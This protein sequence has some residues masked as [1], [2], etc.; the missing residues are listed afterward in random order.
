MGHAHPLEQRADA[1][2]MMERL[3][4]SSA[5]AP[6]RYADLLRRHGARLGTPMMRL[7]TA[8]GAL[9]A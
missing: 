6:W 1:I 3:L 4:R 2:E 8:V 7:H 5:I 9:P